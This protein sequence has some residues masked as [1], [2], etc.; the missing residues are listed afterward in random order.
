[1]GRQ[2]D[3][4]A[5]VA[6]AV[7]LIA[8]ASGCG[9]R[10][11]TATGPVEPYRG[12]ALR[13]AVLGDPGLAEAIDDRRGEWERSRGGSVSIDA[14]TEAEA[15]D[16]DGVDL[17][18]FPGDRLGALIDRGALAPLPDSLVAP[19]EPDDDRDADA[20]AGGLPGEE[21]AY[22]QVAEPYR[23]QVSK[24]GG[25][26]VA[27]PLG[28]AALV[29]VYRASALEGEAIRAEA[30]AGG[31][32]LDVPETW[33]QLD[34]LARFLDGKDWDGDGQAE[35]GIALALGGDEVDRLGAETF[36]ARASA[37]GLHRDDF[38]FLF[39]PDSMAPRLTSPPFVESLE[40]LVSLVD[41]GPEGMAGFDAE[42][43]RSAF[44]SGEAA[45]LI[46]RADR[47]STWLEPD[48]EAELGVARLP[49]SPK[50]FETL[51]N[52]Y[53]EADP[54][55]RPGYLPGG[56]GWLVG[57]SASSAAPGAAGDFARYL[58]EP[59]TASRLRI[60][61]RVPTIPVRTPLIGQGPAQARDLPGLS[62]RDWSDAVS[63]TFLADRVL[64]GLRIPGA[65]EYLAD[66]ARAV[67]SASSGEEAPGD[68]LEAAAGAWDA[69][70]DGLG[71]DRQ[72]WHYQRSL[73]AFSTADTP[74]R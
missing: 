74:P 70:T 60:D 24:Y 18:V 37:L 17:V 51:R 5:A 26:R 10:G 34:A 49:G 28:G 67:A 56:G 6:L 48:D 72:A 1:M 54:P 31:V 4:A 36:L 59:E 38:S 15:D 22:D 2:G 29:L 35:S 65:R 69:R 44:R 8:A 12:V 11:S 9:Q 14:R 64:V 33:E 13:V 16:L 25:E 39:D 62:S 63:K 46:D 50:M 32:S 20:D 52:A 66:L 57:V 53:D 41:S 40:A 45:L 3:R 58:I 23:E 43:A 19:P 68:A 73:N 61:P 71:R 7:G 21:L 55:N 47:A 30:E 27:L 42:A